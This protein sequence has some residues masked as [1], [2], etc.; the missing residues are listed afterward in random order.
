MFPSVKGVQFA[1]KI[2]IVRGEK[3]ETEVLWH[4]SHSFTGN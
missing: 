4:S 1:V 2:I 3:R